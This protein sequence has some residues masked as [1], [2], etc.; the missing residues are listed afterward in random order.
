MAKCNNDDD[1][2]FDDEILD[3]LVF[4]DINNGDKAEPTYRGGGCLSV[5]IGIVIFLLLPLA[6]GR[7]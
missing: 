1:P 4:Q 3:Y 7:P 6:G 2:F 5:I